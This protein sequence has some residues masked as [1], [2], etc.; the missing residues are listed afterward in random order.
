MVVKI[1]ASPVEVGCPSAWTR[2][3]KVRPLSIQHWLS[4]ALAATLLCFLLG[5]VMIMIGCSFPGM[6]PHV[7]ISITSPRNNWDSCMDSSSDLNWMI[8]VLL[9]PW[10]FSSVLFTCPLAFIGKLVPWFELAWHWCS[11]CFISMCCC[12]CTN[13]FCN[14]S[15]GVNHCVYDI[16]CCPSF[17]DLWSLIDCVVNYCHY[18]HFK[19]CCLYAVAFLLKIKNFWDA[20][21]EFAD[22][23]FFTQLLSTL[24]NIVESD[25]WLES[26]RDD[27][28]CHFTS[29]EFVHILSKKFKIFIDLE[30]SLG[31][32]LVG[33]AFVAEFAR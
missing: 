20:S 8:G 11:Y 13:C 33:L 21:A 30:E 9:K 15:T 24:A 17:C 29:G 27:L 32:F 14:P 23:F 5:S 19:I 26:L 7:P 22:V 12:D 18:F 3:H 31:N 25:M 16:V 6:V 2:C 10:S 4:N 28:S 1:L